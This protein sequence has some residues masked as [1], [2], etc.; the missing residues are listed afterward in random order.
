MDRVTIAGSAFTPA[1]GVRQ[2]L[3]RGKWGRLCH[4]LVGLALTASAVTAPGLPAAAQ[5]ASCTSTT[6]RGA[7]DITAVSYS[8]LVARKLADEMTRR[9]GSKRVPSAETIYIVDLGERI[10]L[11]WAGGGRLCGANEYDMS[12]YR[13]AL[14]TIFGVDA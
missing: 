7:P 13:A 12:V 4:G 5:G 9:S 6:G 10:L 14:R 11:F 1:S 3:A 2:P 8:G